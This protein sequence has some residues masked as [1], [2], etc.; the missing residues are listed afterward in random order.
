MSTWYSR[1]RESVLAKRAEAY[2]ADPELFRRRSRDYRLKNP[3]LVA[4][5][6]RQWAARNTA[7]VNAKTA[8]R[9]A[10][11]R[12][13]IPAW[14]SDTC[15]RFWYAARVAA[16]ELFGVPVHVDH[17]V[18]LRSKF[19]SGLHC[20]ANLQLLLAQPNRL[21]SNVRWPGMWEKL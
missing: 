3:T 4:A 19:V 1:N 5:D 10:L 16:E 17:I 7:A 13:R 9:Y 21:K 6:K 12:S 8:K 20:P 18:P 11:L 15:L 14:S 2:A